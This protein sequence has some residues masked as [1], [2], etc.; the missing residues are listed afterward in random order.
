M[1]TAPESM[2]EA[3]LGRSNSSM[4]ARDTL[5][6]SDSQRKS[7]GG[8]GRRGSRSSNDLFV[9]F[10]PRT[11]LNLV[12]R[13]VLSPARDKGKESRKGSL[14]SS[15][16]SKAAAKKQGFEEEEPTSP[17]VTCIGQVR[18]K[19]RNGKD[20]GGGQQKEAKKESACPSF[21]RDF[22]CFR[23]PCD[24]YGSLTSFKGDKKSS[25]AV[26]AKSLVLIQQETETKS[27]QDASKGTATTHLEQ[28]VSCSFSKRREG[29]Q[30][31][32]TNS[33]VQVEGE[34]QAV[35]EIPKKTSRSEESASIS[36]TLQ[37]EFMAKVRVDEP[38][39]ETEIDDDDAFEPEPPPPNALLLMRHKVEQEPVL[40]SPAPCNSIVLKRSTS[41]PAHCRSAEGQDAISETGDTV[42]VEQRAA[43][44]RLKPSTQKSFLKRCKSVSQSF[45]RSN[46]VHAS[47]TSA[48][49]TDKLFE[50]VGAQTAVL[51]EH[52][53]KQTSSPPGAG[54]TD[55]RPPHQERESD[56]V[57]AA[58][59]KTSETEALRVSLDIVPETWLWE[60]CTVVRQP[61]D[62]SRERRLVD[63]L[64]ADWLDAELEASLWRS[65]KVAQQ[66]S[67][68]TEC[69][70]AA[71]PTSQEISNSTVEWLDT[72]VEAAM[73]KKCSLV[74]AASQHAQN[75]DLPNEETQDTGKVSPLFVE[76]AGTPTEGK[77]T[78]RVAA[79]GRSCSVGSRSGKQLAGRGSSL[80]AR[81]SSV[82]SQRDQGYCNMIDEQESKKTCN[83]NPSQKTSTRKL[84]IIE[85]TA[86]DGN[87]QLLKEANREEV[88]I[89]DQR[90]V[91]EE[92][93]AP[94]PS[95]SSVLNHDPAPPPSSPAPAASE[96][97]LFLRYNLGAFRI[98]L[99]AASEKKCMEG[100][101]ENKQKAMLKAMSHLHHEV[102][103]YAR[104]LKAAS[105]KE[106]ASLSS[107]FRLQRCK[108]EPVRPASY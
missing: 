65:C 43:E 17:K 6:R 10:A 30:R 88:L 42:P 56:L 8:G 84:N 24:S 76:A 68:P 19:R 35:P 107:A 82:G 16:F 83:D 103:T 94:S 32:S 27:G 75:G 86:H 51:S 18:V 72:Q 98:S 85:D 49:Q 81:S 90:P 7:K 39:S 89:E 45:T 102:G 104:L 52:T 53:I 34:E 87:R 1:A 9:C 80:L 15:I 58:L 99:D 100:S 70:A 77:K 64:G 3:A 48:P 61:R 2:P 31:Y 33:A 59:R 62:S 41:A 60:S 74:V 71:E 57:N 63:R 5:S 40:V 11:S 78:E 95:P 91:E 69:S 79:L 92:A 55:I 20:A 46:S 26:L 105:G 38:S 101:G 47:A 66:L 50:A 108:S 36:T 37:Q 12:P 14:S 21:A 28:Q 67:R 22:S 106:R 25:G 23:L 13:P 4:D 29:G 44:D 97:L 96:T 73:W 93:L 54:C